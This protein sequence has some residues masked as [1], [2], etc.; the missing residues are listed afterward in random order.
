MSLFDVGQVLAA[1]TDDEKVDLVSGR[2]MWKTTPIP[3]LG[4]PSIVMTDGT[5]GVRYSE[6]Q[7]AGD[8]QGGFDLDDF[9]SVVNRRANGTATA[10]G[11]TRPATCFPTGAALACSWDT[12]LAHRLGAALA[13]ECGEFGVD[14]LLGPGI[15]LR[16]TPLGGRAYEYY[17]EDPL[18]TA[19]IAAAVVDG[20]QDNGVGAS[21]KHFAANNCE[22]ERTTMDSVIEERALREIYLRGFERVVRRSDPWTVMSSY[23]RLNGVQTSQD[24]WLLDTVLRGDWGYRGTVVSDWHGI[25]DRA[26]SIA[27]GNDLD[28][29]ESPSRK[30]ALRRAVADGSVAAADLDTACRRVL[31]LVHRAVAA[32]PSRA[33]AFDRD[34][35]HDLARQM[36]AR[37]MVLL[38]NDGGLLPLNPAALRRVV[39]AGDGAVDPVIQGSGSATTSPTRVDVPLDELRRAFGPAVEVLYD[40]APADIPGADVVVFFANTDLQYD[41]EGADRRTLALAAGQDERIAALAATGVPVVVVVASP[42]AV[43]MPWRDDVPAILATFLAGQGAGRATADVLTG[44]AEPTGRLTTTFPARIEDIPGWLTYP[45]ENGRHVYAEGIHVGY[46]SYDA[47]GREPLFCFGHGL[48]YTTFA[49]GPV[50]A[51]TSGPVTSGAVTSSAVAG[52]PA[53]GGPAD[54][55]TLSEG[56]V[57]HLEVPV[58]NTGARRGRETVQIYAEHRDPRVRRPLLALA[59]FAGIELEPGET[60]TVRISVTADD[61]SFWDTARQRW[62]LDDETVRLHAGR[63][64]RDLTSSVDVTTAG[65]TSRHRPV[66]RDTQPSFILDNPVARAATAA[67]LAAALDRSE[68]E[69]DSMLEYSRDSFIGIVATLERRFRISFT[70]DQADRLLAAIR[71]AG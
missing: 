69:V 56:G 42:D 17:S 14:V 32:R 1:L 34:A 49:T 47:L 58:T 46:R 15:N 43:V 61:L 10:W 63:S 38:K 33:T 4:V 27:A 18:V 45:G 60:G 41:G 25:K 28:M 44:A 9:L 48:G 31:E 37:S 52:G 5:Y 65:S 8:E 62:V 22:V 53:A 39:V 29:P 2:G 36:A 12:G 59:G 66:L 51:V 21:L 50:T 40:P 64:S 3:R 55:A 35:H 26:A 67:F 11:R 6:S 54:V 71:D 24:P 19:E 13:A 70:D 23:N 7:I 30:A 57:V 68:A 20:L 16:R